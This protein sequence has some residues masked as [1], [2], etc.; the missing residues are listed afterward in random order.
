M[1]TL[2]VQP[3]PIAGIVASRGS[4]AANLDTVDPREVWAD[5]ASGSATLTVDLGQV[6]TI[7]TVWLGFVS[8]PGAAATWQVT[9]GAA[10]AGQA[11]LQ[12]SAPL[13]V[14]D[15]AGRFA[16]TTS[17]LWFG[18]AASVRYLAITV[19]Q[20]GGAPL[21]IGRLLV[22]RAV[23]PTRGKEWGSGN[24][25][26]DG[27]SATTL[28][29]GGFAAVEGARRRYVAWTF[30]DLLP[31]EVEALEELALDVGETRAALVIDDPT[32]SA[33]LRNRIYYGRFDRWKAFERRNP[34]QTR[35]ELGF[36]EYL[37]VPAELAA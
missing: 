22:G 4:G 34:Q 24:R 30:G 12:A 2:I 20:A 32:R 35:W 13:R 15:V 28:P 10:S 8:P 26:V 29:T 31:A 9:G 33:G 5:S 37:W 3:L 19:Q 36:E 18:T 7:D 21:S 1:T 14:P 16:S 6:R 17:A 11:T 25:V 23:A 27:G